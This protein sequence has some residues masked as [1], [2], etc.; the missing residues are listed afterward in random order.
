MYTERT[1][2]IDKSEDMT[3]LVGTTVVFYCNATTDSS[4]HPDV[5]WLFNNKQ[6]DF[7]KQSQITKSDN[8]LTIFTTSTM[9]SGNYTC[10]VKTELDNATASVKL[11]VE[12]ELLN[13]VKVLVK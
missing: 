5:E 2:I 11:S 1:Q 3:V 4:L 6:I 7:N 8:S 9:N 10:V 12:G 13:Q